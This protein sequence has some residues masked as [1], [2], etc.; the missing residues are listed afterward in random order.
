MESDS[1]GRKTIKVHDDKIGTVAKIEFSKFLEFSGL[2]VFCF[3]SDLNLQKKQ[4][5]N[6]VY[7]KT[8]EISST[9]T[10]NSIQ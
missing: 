10:K 7:L 3:S 5:T 4:I 1:L 9:Y 8:E 2:I 6:A